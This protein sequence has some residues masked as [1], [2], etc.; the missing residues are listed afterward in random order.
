[1]EKYG[2]AIQATDDNIIW[3]LR[4][5]CWITKATGTHSEYVILVLPRQQWLRERALILRYTYIACLFNVLYA[6]CFTFHA[7]CIFYVI[8]VL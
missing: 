3:R 2:R 7:F 5:E 4:F 8:R 1:V 6:S